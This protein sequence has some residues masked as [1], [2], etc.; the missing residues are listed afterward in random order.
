MKAIEFNSTTNK[1]GYLEIRYRLGEKGKK[2]R[3]LILLEDDAG[4]T[5]EERLWLKSMDEN[6]AFD[7]LKEPEQDIY[8]PSDGEPIN[9]K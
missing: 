7:F 8:S 2:V 6:P 4:E 5:E 3:V 9:D 1:E